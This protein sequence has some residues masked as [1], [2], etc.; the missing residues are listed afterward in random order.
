[1]FKR[2]FL[3]NAAPVKNKE[4][5]QHFEKTATRRADGRFVL[6]LPVKPEVSQLGDS[7]SMAMSRFISVERRLS[8]DEQLRTEYVKFMTQYLEMGHMEEVIEN[9]IPTSRQFYLP[10][11][12]VVKTASLTTKVRVV[13]D[14][15]AKSSSGL[16]LND[17]LM[18]GPSIQEELFSILCRFRSHQFVIT[19]AT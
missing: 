3:H 19:A 14:A 1:M 15:S 10:H 4:T 17:V 5:V 2:E 8:R 7:I 13:F 6:R 9:E 16:S 12:A 18:C 11:H